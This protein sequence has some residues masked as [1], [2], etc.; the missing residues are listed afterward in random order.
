MEKNVCKH[1]GTA[2]DGKVV[3][4]FPDGAEQGRCT[5][6]YRPYVITVGGK[7]IEPEPE[8]EPESEPEAEPKEE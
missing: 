6:C 5:R 3:E 7:P 2:L 8:P 4:V 1:C